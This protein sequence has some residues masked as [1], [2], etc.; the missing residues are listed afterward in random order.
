MALKDSPNEYRATQDE[1]AKMGHHSVVKKNPS[2]MIKGHTGVG[3][4]ESMYLE[5]CSLKPRVL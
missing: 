5:V 1:K 2:I 4:D 3:V